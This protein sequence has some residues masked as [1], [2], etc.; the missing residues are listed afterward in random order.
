MNVIWI[1]SDTFR[2]DHVGAYGNRWIHT[3]SIDALAADAVRFDSHYSAGFPTMPT[4]A[5]HQTGRW[6]MSFMGWQPLPTGVTTLA[7]IL[8]G[9]GMHTAASVDTPYYIRD[10]MNYDRGFQSFFMN[11]GQDTLWSL[12][13]EP[14]YHHEGLD[15]R[16]AW[17]SE[18]DRNA[19]KTFMSAIQ[20]LERHYKEDFF[21]YVDTWDPHEPWDAPSYY[22]ELYLPEYDGE[23]VL[24]LYGNWHDVPGY[25]E[26]QMRKGHATY[27][28]EITMV[29]T[30]VGFLLKSVENMGLADKTV[31]IFTTDHGFYF[32]EHGGLFGK[33]SSDKYPDGTLRP[34]DEPGSQ[35]SYSPLFEEIVHLPLVIRSPEIT[36]GIYSGLSSAID[37]MP[38]VLDLL[39][40]DVPAF[41]QG[42]S[43]APA[44]RDNSFHG[45]EY[46]VSSLPFAN[47]GDPV[48]SV[49]NFL[50]DLK[51][52]P[53]TT[54]TS[55]EWSLLYS[56]A[57]GVSQLYN[58]NTDPQQLDNVIERHTD[59]AGDIH[60]LLVDFMRENES[61]E[62][63]LQ[64]R[65]ELRL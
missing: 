5:D 53:V 38:T 49:D 44:M 25:E 51:D 19:P 43:L 4:R 54:V 33:M 15:V 37:V 48:L 9:H 59:I 61:P 57:P 39:G 10:G 3:P 34:Y 62:R 55:G 40:L 18:S 42:R 2:R 29:D 26:A 22:T 1:V 56:P 52:P 23:L 13:P 35:W 11:V 58:L 32:G 36:P 12:I 64:P 8:A 30:W 17:R 60:K 41:V 6:T 47:P 21:L 63:L 16:D 14:G 24:P 20:W 31:V 45:R 28:G 50:R 7:E 27:C 65:L 46:V